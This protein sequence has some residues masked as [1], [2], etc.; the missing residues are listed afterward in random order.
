MRKS[1]GYFRKVS[2]GEKFGFCAKGGD[3]FNSPRTEFHAS[4]LIILF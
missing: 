2:K 1:V 4:K 3:F